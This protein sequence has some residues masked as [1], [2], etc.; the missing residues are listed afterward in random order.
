MSWPPLR[1]KKGCGGR[2]VWE[3][4]TLLKVSDQTGTF[5][6]AYVPEGGYID[7]HLGESFEDRNGNSHWR[8][9]HITS[10]TEK[11]RLMREKNVVEDGGWKKPVR[12]Q[13]FDMGR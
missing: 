1:A 10:R 11:A 8:P 9:A 12:R 7:E 3:A 6:D 2:Y 5:F 13:Y 4:G